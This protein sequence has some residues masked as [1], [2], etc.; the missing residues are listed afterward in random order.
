MSRILSDSF[1]QPYYSKNP[2][3]GG[4]GIGE[5]VYKR[6]YAREKEDGHKENWVETLSR[7]VEG[8]QGIGAGYSTEEAQELFDLLFNL[9][10]SFAGRSLWQLGTPMIGL[11]GAPSL[12]NCWVLSLDSIEAFENL[13]LLSMNGGGVGY[14]LERSVIHELPKVKE[15]VKIE[16]EKTPDADLIVPDSREGWVRL[17]HSVLKSFFYTGRSFTYSTILVRGY[18]AKLHRFGGT[19]SGPEVLIEGVTDICKILHAREGKKIRSIDALDICNIIGKVVVAGNARR[20][21]QLALGDPDDTLFLKAKRWGSMNIPDWRGNSNN[22]II[23]DSYDELTD[24]YWRNWDGNSEC[25]GLLNRKLARTIG[26]IGEPCDDRKVVGTNP[27]GEIFLE[28]GESCNLAEIFLPNI[29]SQKEFNTVSKLLYKTQ[30]AITTLPY[31]FKEAQDVVRRNRRLGQGVTGWLQST[32]EQLS[33]LDPGY[34]NLRKFDKEWSEKIG[35]NQ[36]IKLTTVKPSGTLSLLPF[37]TPGI[38]PGLSHYFIRRVR[39]GSNDPLVQSA[40]TAGYGVEYD[41]LIDG[42]LDYRKC[43][44]DFPCSL[45]ETTIVANQM[46]AIQQMEWVVKAQTVW[47][48]NAVS[49]SVYY[50]K[51]ELPEIKVW[52]REN[53][54]NKIKSISFL[55]RQDHGFKLPPLEAI[56]KDQYEKMVSKLKP[57]EIDG[58]GIDS[59]LECDGG[60]CPIR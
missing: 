46:T 18:G 48:D 3:F 11:F 16:H 19:A 52:L 41:I 28:P 31:P 22:S 36:S 14:T 35:V 47:S 6:T 50:E 42:S 29:E 57:I 2:G 26:R 10:G 43:V 21:A 34:K 56:T 38:H 5:F 44:I 59:S 49:V 25:Y 1:L 30:K 39:V 12:I 32:E 60:A 17:L 45:P 40:K 27:C 20:S 55:L 8:A 58:D 51:Q 4:N 15:D 37:I 9:K 7:C 54:K 13:M 33:Y 53:Y 24:E 23:A